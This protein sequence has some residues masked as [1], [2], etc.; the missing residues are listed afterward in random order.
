[1][2]GNTMKTLYQFLCGGFIGVGYLFNFFVVCVCVKDVMTVVFNH[3][4]VRSVM[5]YDH[6]N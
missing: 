2:N 6:N 3:P 1:M 4:S 5:N